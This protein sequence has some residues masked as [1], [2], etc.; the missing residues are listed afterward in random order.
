MTLKEIYKKFPTEKAA[1]NY[2]FNIR[3]NG[4]LSCPHCGTDVEV[5][6]YKERDKVCHCHS[7]N[8][9][10]SPFRDTIFEKTHSDIRDWFYAI[11]QLAIN[12]RKGISACQLQRD[13]GC[14]YR[15]AGD[16]A[17]TMGSEKRSSR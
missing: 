5:Y 13:L 9:S 2:F 14:G 17:E 12:A 16:G 10:F 7:C 8:N 6:R 15:T 4:V 11:N 3:Y 1:I